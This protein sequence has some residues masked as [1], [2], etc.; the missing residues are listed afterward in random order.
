MENNVVETNKNKNLIIGVME[1]V[2]ILLIA[3]LVYFVFIK[4]ADKPVDNKEG[5]N[6]QVIDNTTNDSSPNKT[7]ESLYDGN[8]SYGIKLVSEYE[9]EKT[10]VSIY[11]YDD[12]TYYYSVQGEME[13]GSLGTYSIDNNIIVLNKVFE[14]GN[15]SGMTFNK[16]IESSKYTIKSDGLYDATS[17]TLKYKKTNN[18][19]ANGYKLFEQLFNYMASGDNLCLSKAEEGIHIDSFCE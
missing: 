6:Q 12:G 15:G 11:L 5:N 17:G 7:K 8:L 3:A 16:K 4:K 14:H 13:S 19:D 1:C 10:G 2:I 9:D 18:N